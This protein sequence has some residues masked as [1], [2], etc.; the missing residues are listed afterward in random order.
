MWKNRH[1]NTTRP[2]NLDGRQRRR[3]SRVFE[4]L[5]AVRGLRDLVLQVY[6]LFDPEQSPHQAARRRMIPERGATPGRKQ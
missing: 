3:L 5:P 6:R 1:L 4:S 2:D